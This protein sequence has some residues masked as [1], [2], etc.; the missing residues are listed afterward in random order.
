M[1]NN[2]G[3]TGSTG[4][5]NWAGDSGNLSSQDLADYMNS[6]GEPGGGSKK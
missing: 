2:S 3:S 6:G 5:S 1:S 4:F